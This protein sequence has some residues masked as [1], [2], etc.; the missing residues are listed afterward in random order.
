MM[1]TLVIGA[2]TK[3]E[4]YSNIAIN[5]LL[6]YDHEVI[7]YGMRKGTVCTVDIETDWNAEWMVDTVTMYI[8][9]EAQEAYTDKIIALHPRRVIFNPET[10]NPSFYEKL[11]NEGIEVEEA[12][13]L[14]LLATNAY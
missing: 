6:D 14:V 11:R 9:P 1:K 4:R 7:A 8:N 10:E 12:C 13:T 5:R 3:P 2:S